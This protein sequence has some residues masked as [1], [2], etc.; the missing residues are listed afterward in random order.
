MNELTQLTDR[1]LLAIEHLLNGENM[2]ATADAVGVSRQTLHEWQRQPLFQHELELQRADRQSTFR[3][4]WQR[5]SD[6]VSAILDKALDADNLD[7]KLKAASLWLKHQA[8]APEPVPL[9]D[10]KLAALQFARDALH[11]EIETEFILEGKPRF[12]GVLDG[13][14]PEMLKKLCEPTNPVDIELENRLPDRLRKLGLLPRNHRTRRR[15]TTCGG[16]G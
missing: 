16:A 10:T 12:S 11:R 5:M 6:K 8:P 15:K 3:E 4:R 2:T 14:T 9:L 1:Q 13:W 7:T